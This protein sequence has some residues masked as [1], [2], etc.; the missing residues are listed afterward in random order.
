VV[1]LSDRGLGVDDF[2]PTNTVGREDPCA[3][4]TLGWKDRV[5]FFT[6][7]VG[8]NGIRDTV[9]INIS[10]KLGTNLTFQTNSLSTRDANWWSGIWAVDT[11]INRG[12]MTGVGC[13]GWGGSGG[14]NGVDTKKIKDKKTQQ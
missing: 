5:E 10:R 7:S 9:L 13:R 14:G 12:S 11:G 1:V 3:C 6:G 4:G 2:I 8:G